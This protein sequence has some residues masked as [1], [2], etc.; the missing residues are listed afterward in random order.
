MGIVLSISGFFTEWAAIITALIAG[1]A[2]LF[3]AIKLSL[4]KVGVD[5]AKLKSLG[6]DDGFIDFLTAFGLVEK[7]AE[8]EAKFPSVDGTKTGALKEA[9]LLEQAKNACAENGKEYVESDW[10]KIIALG[11]ESMNVGLKSLENNTQTDK[12]TIP[13]EK[14][15]S[16]F[17]AS[18][19][20]DEIKNIIKNM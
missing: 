16:L 5:E 17:G 15:Q 2:T 12:I 11:V 20:I 10:K 18:L 14:A 19:S 9:D 6:V 8:E 3:A 4:K 7:I 13:L 1:I